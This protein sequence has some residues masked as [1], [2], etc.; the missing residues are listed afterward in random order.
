MPQIAQIEPATPV[1]IFGANI[2][3]RPGIALIKINITDKSVESGR[4]FFKNAA[5]RVEDITCVIICKIPYIP[6]KPDGTVHHQL[7]SL[8]SDIILPS[9]PR[10]NANVVLN[11]NVC[12]LP[13]N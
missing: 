1:D 7:Q 4:N 8:D 5:A 2:F 11:P 10:K 9:N 12:G 3:L 6:T 13:L